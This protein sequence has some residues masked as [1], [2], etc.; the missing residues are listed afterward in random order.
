[1]RSNVNVRGLS[2]SKMFERFL[3][4]E[5]AGDAEIMH[6]CGGGGVTKAVFLQSAGLGIA[7]AR[8]NAT[9]RHS[10]RVLREF[11]PVKAFSFVRVIAFVHRKAKPCDIFLRM[12][13]YSTLLVFC[14]E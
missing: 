11:L 5:C 7:K 14:L 1:M 13:D 10:R 4:A 8:L 3:Y 12:R 6:L 9:R 2:P